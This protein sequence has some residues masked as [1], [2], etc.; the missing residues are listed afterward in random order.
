MEHRW[1]R[2]QPRS[3]RHQVLPVLQVGY[4]WSQLHAPPAPQGRL[5]KGILPREAIGWMWGRQERPLRN[6]LGSWEQ[7]GLTTAVVTPGE[8]YYLIHIRERAEER[9]N[10]WAPSLINPSVSAGAKRSVLGCFQRLARC[11]L[12]IQPCTLSGPLPQL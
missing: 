2:P 9:R 1:K 8:E 4:R 7:L 5:P 10:D 11:G 6:L 12:S 3:L